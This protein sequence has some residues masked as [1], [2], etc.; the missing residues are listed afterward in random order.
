MNTRAS[1]LDI[2]NVR[3]LRALME[4]GKTDGERQAATSRAEVL[5]EAA[6]Y[7]ADRECQGGFTMKDSYQ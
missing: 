2:D 4:G 1:K 5:A 7:I 6:R 3:K